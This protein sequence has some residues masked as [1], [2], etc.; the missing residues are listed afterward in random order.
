MRI[1]ASTF[2]ES[3]ERRLTNHKE[4]KMS[5]RIK[6]G[7]I[8]GGVVAILNFCGGSLVGVFNNCLAIV[9]VTIAAIGA[10]YLSAQQEPAEEAIKAGGIAGAI[11]GG[12][13][14]ISQ[15]IIS[16]IAGL[17]GS[18]MMA[19]FMPHAQANA[20]SFPQSTEVGLDITL[21]AAILV[22]LMLILGGAGIGAWA[23]KLAKPK[24]DATSRRTAID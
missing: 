17:I 18:G 5:P 23:A 6:W 8:T 12:I 14:L 7:L 22:G 19:Y 16:F 20:P 11:V 1:F 24:T 10:G 2:W 4:I 21:F 3:I 9:T 13:N 15:L